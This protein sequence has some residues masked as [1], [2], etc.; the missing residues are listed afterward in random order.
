MTAPF[1]TSS[2]NSV[3]EL[4]ESMHRLLFTVANSNAMND[5]VPGS[6]IKY[7]IAPWQMGVYGVTGVLAVL[8]ALLGFNAFKRMKQQ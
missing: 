1:D 7:G 5:V 3:S 6:R 8:A 2:A 4:R